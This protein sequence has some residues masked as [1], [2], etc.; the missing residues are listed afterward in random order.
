V[1]AIEDS[2]RYWSIDLPGLSHSAARKLLQI[3]V[4]EGL[5][6]AGSLVDPGQ[7]LTL[8]IDSQ[9]AMAVSVALTEA[10][11]LRDPS[12]E[13]GVLAIRGFKEELQEWLDETEDG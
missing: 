11:S 4:G 10:L 6:E 7:F 9:T 13:A 12:S 8:H 5:A 3:A 2:S 1:T